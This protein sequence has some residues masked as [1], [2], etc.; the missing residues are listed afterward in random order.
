MVAVELGQLS[1]VGHAVR[2]V[3]DLDSEDRLDHVLSA[4]E[5]FVDFITGLPIL[6]GDFVT[7]SGAILLWALAIGSVKAFAITLGIATVIDVTVALRI[8]PAAL[9]SCVAWFIHAR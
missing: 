6:T 1:Q 8:R 5:Q 2:F 4:S 3:D 9:A 7:F